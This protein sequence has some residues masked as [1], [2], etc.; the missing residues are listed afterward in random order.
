MAEFRYGDLDSDT[1]NTIHESNH[2]DVEI[3]PNGNVVSVWFRCMRV[4]FEAH[5]VDQH[6]ANDMLH[7]PKPPTLY[8]III[9]DP[10]SNKDG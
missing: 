1:R 9:E 8:A 5:N 2:V 6:R 3:G 4:P 7:D 10:R